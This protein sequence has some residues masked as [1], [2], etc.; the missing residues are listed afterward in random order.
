MF[1]NYPDVMTMERVSTASEILTAKEAAA[2]LRIGRS[3]MY[4]L[5]R[6]GE[7]RSLRVGRKIVIPRRAIELYIGQELCYHEKNTK[8]IE[9]VPERSNFL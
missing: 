5:L 7:L 2:L 8:K 6:D 3:S 9:P 4:R 1:Q